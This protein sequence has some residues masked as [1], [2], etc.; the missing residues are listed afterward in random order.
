MKLQFNYD[1]VAEY[2]NDLM[3]FIPYKKWASYI[4]GLYYRDG[5][6]GN[7]FLD[8][9]AGTGSLAC[10]LSRHNLDVWCLDNSLEML[11][12]IHHRSERIDR[13]HA[14]TGDMR[15]LPLREG[16]DAAVCM[17][18]TVNHFS[19]D[20]MNRVLRNVYDVLRDNGLFYFDFNT[21]KGLES[22]A[23]GDFIRRSAGLTSKWKTDY[24]S[25]TGVCKL[26]LVIYEDDRITD[27]LSFSERA[28]SIDEVEKSVY[29]AGFS[30]CRILEFLTDNPAESDT[31]RGFAVC[32]K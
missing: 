27:T 28:V 3:Q 22:F 26:T 21:R 30:H 15:Q 19:H 25:K 8:L 14:I 31:E 10:E 20:D 24:S 2:Y 18:D 6:S 16:F 32:R 9:G 7:A 12:M 5:A 13:I 23:D 4:V 29:K 17:Y 11:K 1:S